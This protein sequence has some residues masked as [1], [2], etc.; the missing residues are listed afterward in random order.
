MFELNKTEVINEFVEQL[1]LLTTDTPYHADGIHS[2]NTLEQRIR[3]IM[4]SLWVDAK[5]KVLA[6]HLERKME[7]H[8]EQLY[9]F[10]YGI[11][12]YNNTEPPT[13]QRPDTLAI[14]IIEEKELYQK[15]I[16]HLRQ[17]YERFK[18]VCE[19]LIFYDK[20]L[21]VSYFER[22]EKADYERLRGAIKHNL[23]IFENT[24]IK[25]AV[26]GKKEEMELHLE[27]EHRK[28]MNALLG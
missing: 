23:K 21:I 8:F 18:S 1:E 15:R 22:S 16:K 5:S 6:E 19:Q 4:A 13:A 10:S 9:E 24:Y 20:E 12:S 2:L 11:P 7:S 26:R 3:D 28:H 14:M 17:R 27:L 25:K